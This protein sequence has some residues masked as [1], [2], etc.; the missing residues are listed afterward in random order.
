MRYIDIYDV[1]PEERLV[2]LMSGEE[3]EISPDKF[4]EFIF[5]YRRWLENRPEQ[6][7]RVANFEC[8]NE[9]GVYCHDKYIRLVKLREKKTDWPDDVIS[10]ANK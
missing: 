7:D 1:Y 2:M 10:F 4:E 6:F 3:V 9:H 8:I 5:N